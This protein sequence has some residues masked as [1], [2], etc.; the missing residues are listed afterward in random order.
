MDTNSSNECK[1]L[2]EE[3]LKHGF[4]ITLLE[5]ELIWSDYCVLNYCATWLPIEI[6]HHTIKDLLDLDITKE[7]LYKN[8]S[9]FEDQDIN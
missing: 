2:K 5:A 7:I 6:T 3:F 1:K 8:F 4:D 9:S